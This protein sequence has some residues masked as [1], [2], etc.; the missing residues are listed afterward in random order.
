M[1]MLPGRINQQDPMAGG[2]CNLQPAAAYRYWQISNQWPVAGTT[3]RQQA[4]RI[5]INA[6]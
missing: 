3:N 5:I 1:V 4:A 6:A 2:S